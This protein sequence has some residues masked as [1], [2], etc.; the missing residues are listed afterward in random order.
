MEFCGR[1]VPP[2][3]EKD[4]AG[5]LAEGGAFW[6]RRRRSVP[7]GARSLQKRAQTDRVSCLQATSRH[8]GLRSGERK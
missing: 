4:R 2:A 3:R 1:H 7:G 6:P 5:F 8:F